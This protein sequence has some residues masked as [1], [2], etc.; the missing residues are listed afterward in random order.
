M[1]GE[2]TMRVR[3]LLLTIFVVAALALSA[4]GGA[5]TT[6][7]AAGDAA[8]PAAETATEAAAAPAEGDDA[9][10]PAEGG[11]TDALGCITIASGEPIKIAYAMVTSGPNG[12]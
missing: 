12:S 7:P 2:L 10:A 1:Q 5:A 11:C 3:A 6:A 8:A 4:C 9:A